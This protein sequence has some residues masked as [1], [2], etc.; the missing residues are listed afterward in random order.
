VQARRS[1]SWIGRAKLQKQNTQLSTVVD[2]PAQRA[3]TEVTLGGIKWPQSS[4]SSVKQSTNKIYYQD[5]MYEKHGTYK[6]VGEI[7][8]SCAHCTSQETT[9][10]LLSLISINQSINLLK[11]KGPIVHLHRSKIHNIKYINTQI[12]ILLRIT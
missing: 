4:H 1:S 8:K 9:K 2:E 10:K 11:A 12:H 3:H 6:S 7:N 5:K